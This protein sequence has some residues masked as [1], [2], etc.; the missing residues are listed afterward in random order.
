[1]TAWRR[2]ILAVSVAAAVLGV[3]TGC[4]STPGRAAP[5]STGSPAAAAHYG[6]GP[7]HD[8]SMRYRP[9]VVLIDGGPDAIRSV[10]GDGMTWTLDPTAGGMDRLA[11]GKI[12]FA[13]AMAVGR[14]AALNRTSAGEQVLLAP[15]QL[16][17]LLAGGQLNV[18]Q[19]IDPGR[20]TA[21]VFPGQP[22]VLTTGDAAAPAATQTSA[23]LV[24]SVTTAG[25]AVPSGYL[26]APAAG[27]AD[28]G[29]AS[30][31]RSASRTLAVPPAQF[32]ASAD[33]TMGNWMVRPTLDANTIG[34]GLFA[35]EQNLVVGA[36]IDVTHTRLHLHASGDVGSGIVSGSGVVLTG[37]TGV[38][39]SFKAGMGGSTSANTKVRFEIPLEWVEPIPPSP[40]TAGLPMVLRVGYR[41]I[42]ETAFGAK[43]STLS[44]SGG[45][46]LT[47]GIG[48]TT[49][50]LVLPTWGLK[51]SVMDSI[52][53]VYLAP[54]GLV[55]AG[56][57]KVTLGVGIPF[58][59]AGP[60][61]VIYASWGVAKGSVLGSPLATCRSVTA[62]IKVGAGARTVVAAPVLTALQSMLPKNFKL[63]LGAEV[64]FTVKHAQQTLPDVPICVTS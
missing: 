34:L 51:D 64:L 15:I 43:N 4:S 59:M 18:D 62:D 27:S 41:A 12:M 52:S 13:S 63:D 46:T 1:M 24:P 35:Q 11:V 30:A 7:L 28:A 20:L 6:Y 5:P 49:T 55:V 38:H 37:I 2:R 60:Y 36:S 56:E 22:G 33:V 8:A 58:A 3:A 29:R 44:A 42:L 31:A 61:G 32:G 25:I 47:G 54:S 17:D 23:Y 45:Y 50:G 21:D 53:G 48:V 14:V 10:S 57:Y 26:L 9:D 39:V 40:A 16:S 19:D